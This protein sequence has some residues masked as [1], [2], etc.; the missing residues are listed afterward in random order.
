MNAAQGAAAAT[1]QDAVAG[2]EWQPSVTGAATDQAPS[3][4]VV[5]IAIDGR[6]AGSC[7]QLGNPL[8]VRAKHR[9]RRHQEPFGPPSRRVAKASSS[10]AA[11]R[12]STVSKTACVDCTASRVR[13]AWLGI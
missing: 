9:V 3:L 11:E 1:G 2:L 7:S 6:Q 10:C 8:T 13:T 12:I 5:A 4:D